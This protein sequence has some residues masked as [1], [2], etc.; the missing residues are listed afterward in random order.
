MNNYSTQNGRRLIDSYRG[1]AEK[2][3]ELCN[4]IN[5]KAMNWYAL[6]IEF[7]PTEVELITKVQQTMEE[8]KEIAKLV[9]ED[10]DKYDCLDLGY[11]VYPTKCN[12][13]GGETKVSQHKII[14]YGFSCNIYKCIVC[15]QQ[16][17]EHQ[18]NNYKDCVLYFPL[19]Y[20]FFEEA[21]LSDNITEETLNRVRQRSIEMHEKEK[22][23]MAYIDKVSK[24]REP[25]KEEVMISIKSNGELYKELIKQ[26]HYFDKNGSKAI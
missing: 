9:A 25:L 14:D 23:M 3:Y 19:V 18:P 5:K 15:G 1:G 21:L 22:V 16:F 24:E 17:E 13:C 4:Y 6:N 20:A 26:K 8:M 12:D 10:E 2:L 7:S 11:E